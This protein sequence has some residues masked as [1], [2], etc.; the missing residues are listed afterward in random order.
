LPWTIE[1]HRA[2]AGDLHGLGLPGGQERVVRLLETTRPALVLGSTQQESIVVGDATGLD[3][4]RRR[5][6]GGAVLV[7]PGRVAWIDVAIGRADPL[8]DD[9]VGRAFHWLGDAWA[10]ALR[11]L[12]MAGGTVHRGGL[13]RTPLSDLVCFAGLGPGEVTV[14]GA[15]VVGI[16]QRRT[17][18]GALFQCA[19]PLE[20]NPGP[21]AALLGLERVDAPVLSVVGRTQPELLAALVAQLPG[22]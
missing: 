14:A 12:G 10:A 3:V 4:V 6:G 2:P 19:L 9:D 11:L 21:L 1:E 15:K 17:R 7:E 22:N 16:A 13:I 18:D 20:W 5:S 8:W